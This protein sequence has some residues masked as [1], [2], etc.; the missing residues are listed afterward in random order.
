M[1]QR[2]EIRQDLR[3][4]NRITQQQL[5]FVRMLELN[6]RELEE[7]V[8]FELE[9]NPALEVDNEVENTHQEGEDNIP[10][11]RLRDYNRSNDE[12]ANIGIVAADTGE[13]LYDHLYSQ[14]DQF[15]LN[16]IE[17]AAAHYAVGSIDP[18]GYLLRS[19]NALAED[20]LFNTGID[21]GIEVM[22]RMVDIIKTLDPPGVGASGLQEALIIQLKHKPNSFSR[23][24]ALRILSEGFE[25]FS[26]KHYE[27]LA[28][29]FRINEHELRDAVNTILQLNPKPGAAYDSDSLTSASRAIIPDFIIEIEG[30]NISIEIPNSHDDLRIVES[31]SNAIARME[32]EKHRKENKESKFVKTC[33]SDAR[34]FIAVLKRRRETLF[35]VISA[36]SKIQR[37]YLLSG[38]EHQLR[39]MALKDISELTGLDLSVIS[40]ATSDKYVAMPWGVKPLRFFFSEAFTDA[41]G[42]ITSGRGAEAAIRSLVDN[43]DSSRP[44]SDESL[45]IALQNKGYTLSRR[46]VAKYRDRMGIP[47]WRL[48]KK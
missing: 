42:T 23:D 15:K 1:K 38:D 31:F 45:R 11:Y 17:Q 34:D 41:S 26:L 7:A 35:S 6:S 43:E 14:L 21:P 8:E 36:I 40:R 5:R 30:D 27:K 25:E 33:Y 4:Q 18:S 20:M 22:T 46:T 2:Q 47:I 44:M 16:P 10:Y 12:M 3:L 32:K 29:R 9:S 48:R 13:S 19:P 24:L 39:P 28:R 37:D